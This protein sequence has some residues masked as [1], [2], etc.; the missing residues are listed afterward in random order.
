MVIDMTHSTKDLL[1]RVNS[2][3]FNINDCS[4]SG[5]LRLQGLIR[6]HL[7]TGG[8]GSKHTITGWIQRFPALDL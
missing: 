8:D 4:H 1:I 7:L 2:L 6:A 5:E 3:L